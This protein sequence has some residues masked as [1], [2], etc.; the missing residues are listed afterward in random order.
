MEEINSRVQTYHACGN[1]R[2]SGNRIETTFCGMSGGGDS[3]Q[4]VIRGNRRAITSAKACP[5]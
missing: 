2:E 4:N 1:T 5:I 3:A